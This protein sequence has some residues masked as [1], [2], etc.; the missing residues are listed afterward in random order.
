MSSEIV[1]CETAGRMAFHAAH[2]RGR[3]VR[4]RS[5]SLLACKLP[6]SSV[7]EVQNCPS[8]NSILL[9]CAAPHLPD[10]DS[11]FPFLFR[12]RQ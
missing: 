4:A 11:L 5:A 8:P 10:K 3:E 7:G 12:S 2:N 6:G 1:A 9:P